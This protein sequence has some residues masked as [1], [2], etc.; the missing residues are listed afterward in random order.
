MNKE[1]FQKLSKN[2]PVRTG[3]NCR[4][5]LSERYVWIVCRQ[6]ECGILYW[7]EAIN[8]HTLNSGYEVKD[9]LNENK[10]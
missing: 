4:P 9:F 7:I 1:V 3:A 10:D 6:E 2:C 8:K 5:I